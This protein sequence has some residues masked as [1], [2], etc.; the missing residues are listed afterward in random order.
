MYTVIDHDLGHNAHVMEV[1]VPTHLIENYDHGDDPDVNSLEYFDNLKQHN[2]IDRM[3]FTFDPVHIQEGITY[4]L[5]V[6]CEPTCTI[7]F[8]QENTYDGGFLSISG[9]VKGDLDFRIDFDL[10]ACVG[11]YFVALPSHDCLPIRQCAPGMFESIKPSENNNRICESCN[12]GTYTDQW[13]ELNCKLP[14]ICTQGEEFELVPTTLTSDRECTLATP[15]CSFPEEYENSRLTATSDRVCSTIRS[16]NDF[17]FEEK[18]PSLTTDRSCGQ[19]TICSPG[20][21]PAQEPTPTT[22]TSCYNCLENSYKET[23]GNTLCLKCLKCDDDE[24]E[25]SQCTATNN[26]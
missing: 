9:K 8:S 14:T 15:P 20:Q 4:R 10:D 21:Y 11:S 26:R 17:E 19:V 6:K 2:A 1:S 24:F 7:R 5:S 22:D 12:E 3:I 13:N 18:P 25:S 23:S 16:C